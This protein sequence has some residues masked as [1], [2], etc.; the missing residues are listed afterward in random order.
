MQWL[1]CLLSQFGQRNFA[2]CYEVGPATVHEIHSPYCGCTI[3]VQVSAAKIL[4]RPAR[5]S[6]CLIS[7]DLKFTDRD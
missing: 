5:C 4:E 1:S 2:V 3:S 7:S 6:H